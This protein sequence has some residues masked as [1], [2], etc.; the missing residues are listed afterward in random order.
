M[1]IAKYIGLFLLKNKYCCL[2]GLGNLDIKRKPASI[3]GAAINGSS[4]EA[5]L[6]ITGSIDDAL[7]NFIATN[8]F[9]SIAK[10]S[11]EIS[12]FI[13]YAKRELA[14]GNEVIIPSIGKYLMKNNRPH[15]ELD[16]AFS[17]PNKPIAIPVVINN[18]TP[19]TANNTHREREPRNGNNI[20]WGLI[21]M[22][23]VILI[24]ILLASIFSIKYFTN[25]P[26]D[27]EQVSTPV[28]IAPA[29][30]KDTLIKTAAVDTAAKKPIVTDTP[31]YN[32]I[33]SSYKTFIA[34][35]K[36]EKQLTGYG[37]K[38][39]IITKDSLTF[40]VV[41]PMKLLAVDTTKIKDSLSKVLNPKGV[42]ILQ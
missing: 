6:T 14:A 30:V 12:E 16:P 29:I 24:V 26:K 25:K 39:T 31:E 8:E 1:D 34:A 2:Q 3:D 13:A 38:V 33:I 20:N 7:A 4:Y 37:H 42:S 21:T 18:P 35:Q 5:V 41:K 11:N 23:A 32:F 28:A 40:Y 19:E 15:F 36:R 27:V 17:L 22:W 10:A 9:V